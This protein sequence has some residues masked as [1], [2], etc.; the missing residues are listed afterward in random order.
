MSQPVIDKSTHDDK[1]H[2]GDVTSI[3]LHDG[4]LYSAGSDGKVKVSTAESTEREVL[5]VEKFL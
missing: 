5:M 4:V 2:S 3:V 1:K